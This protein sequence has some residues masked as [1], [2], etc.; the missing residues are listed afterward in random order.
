[1]SVELGSLTRLFREHL[2]GVVLLVVLLIGS[3]IAVRA[4]KASHPGAM[5]VLESQAM[6]MTV[7]KPPVG[8]V[9]VATETVH[10]GSFQAKVTYTG[11]VVPMQEQV[12]YPRVEGTLRSLT[13]Y[14]GDRVRAGQVIAEVDS[15]DLESR[16]AEAAFG[17]AAAASEVPS[18]HYNV[19]R[20][21]A[22]RAAA[23]SEVQAARNDLAR[24]K[25]M[26]SAA[27]RAVTRRQKELKSARADLEYQR[28]EIERE[29]KLLKAGAVSL[30]EYQARKAQAISAE[31]EV[32]SSQAMLE[33]A[34]AG[35]E[36]AKAE[37]AAKE[38]MVRVAQQRASAADAAV[39]SARQ[40]VRQKNAVARQAGAMV[41]TASAIDSYRH[42]RAPFAGS[43]TKRYVSPGQFVT[44]ATAIAG[45]V[46]IDRVRLQANVADKDVG[47]ISVGAPIVA[48]FPKNP[49]LSVNAS[50]TSISPAAD[51][52]S[53][54]SVVE[55]IV[56]NPGHRLLPGDAVTV[57][58]AVSGRTDVISVPASAIVRKNG[59][60]AVWT[61]RSA[62]G[63]GKKEYYCTM[64]PEVV[65]DKPGDCP[66][67]FM[68]LVPRTSD[69]NK[70]AHLVMVTTGRS[71]GDRTEILSGLS[72]GD[73][74]IYMGNTYLSEGDTV[75]ST[76]WTADG[77]ETM[78]QAPAMDEMPEM[79]GMDH[80]SHSPSPQPS[81]Q[82]GEG[83]KVSPRP[84]AKAGEGVKLRSTL[85]QRPSTQ[86]TYICPMHPHEM[87][88]NP[89]D[90]C[91]LCGMKLEEKR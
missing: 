27:E 26:V 35:V 34:R 14:N 58:I 62:T 59:L 32:E 30:A 53:R 48:R 38:S 2:W 54:T 24:S 66:K 80:S 71:D 42:V 5:S 7:M 57:E 72:D 68:K 49:G 25:A 11:S 82:R 83:A 63:K 91:K 41:A 90:R 3:T 18:A 20:M 22:E 8:A 17:R 77:P 78:P 85:S 4:W 10:P 86:K 33:E 44:P 21:A 61:A 39:A 1:M 13:V 43:V 65:S 19:S 37:V 50:V 40:E 6:D 55:A 47:L 79:P 52:S 84:S 45:V 89:N 64:H 15:P 16:V 88:H 60:T 36:A 70:K 31:A 73:E 74:V 12:I 76:R 23:Q 87:S 56:P 46:Q 81:P 69:G 67:C 28:A 51:Q 29:A 9:P 75:F